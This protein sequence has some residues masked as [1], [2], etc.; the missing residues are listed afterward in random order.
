MALATPGFSFDNVPG[1]DFYKWN[2]NFSMAAFMTPVNVDFNPLP[3]QVVYKWEESDTAYEK[4]DSVYERA[5][6]TTLHYTDY[7]PDQ[8]I[9]TQEVI[10]YGAAPKNMSVKPEGSGSSYFIDFNKDG[11]QSCTQQP[12]GA[13]PPNWVSIPAVEGTIQATTSAS[14]PLTHDGQP[15]MIV[16]CLFPSNG[17][18]EESTYLWT[19]YSPESENGKNSRPITF[20]QSESSIGVGTSLAL[21]DYY[22]YNHK[23]EPIADEY[24]MTPDSC[25][26][27]KNLS[28]ELCQ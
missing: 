19:W 9:K 1:Y 2:T 4:S 24:F 28:L 25:N 14:F 8:D 11:T 23:N 6:A 10:M 26:S 18:F 7:N 21:A 5:Q 20:M 15:I 13:E 3:T 16:S 27:K 12:L 17:P 22:D